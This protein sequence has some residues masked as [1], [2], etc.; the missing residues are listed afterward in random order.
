MVDSVEST[1]TANTLAVRDRVGV[2]LPFVIRWNPVRPFTSWRAVEPYV[3][4]AFG[5]LFGAH[6]TVRDLGADG[7]QRDRRE[8]DGRR[9][10]RRGE[11]TF[12]SA[13]RGPPA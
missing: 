12:A 1:S 7:R 10:R 5:P 3:R 4:G 13:G 11:P 9:Q 2:N 8:H 6:N